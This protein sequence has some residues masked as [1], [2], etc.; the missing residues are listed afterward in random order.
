MVERQWIKGAGLV[1]LV[2]A[3]NGNPNQDNDETT[4]QECT[5]VADAGPDQEG[6]LGVGV[7]MD[8]AGSQDC[9]TSGDAIYTWS[10]DSIP[11]DSE[12]DATAFSDN[13]S[14][15]A[16]ATSFVPDAIG[17]YLVAL[18]VE[19]SGVLSELD[20]AIVE[21]GASG[22]VP[23]ADCGGDLEVVLG[24][25]AEL[26]GSGSSDPDG[27]S[28]SYRWTLG[29]VP[30]GSSLDSSAIFDAEAVQASFVPDLVGTY[31]VYL[32]V[33][34][35]Q[36]ESEPAYCTVTAVVPNQA[37]V[38]DAGEGGVMAPCDDH[39]LQL[40]GYGSYDP[41]GLPLEYQW[42]VLTT[43]EGSGASAEPCDT[44]IVGCY[45]AFDD[46]FAADPIFTWDLEGTYTLQ[47]EVY[48]GDLWSAPDVVAY[49][50]SECP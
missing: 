3:C 15:A 33:S 40:D 5:P 28:I 7:A 26:D 48:D 32:T 45:A 2:A 24:E 17:T 19:H 14:A 43:P 10:F 36:Q 9:A 41:E 42:G 1:V 50:V 39:L 16:Q 20:V 46:T 12:L 30:D 13:A 37:P 34:D 38:A 27:E 35:G 49:T 4:P 47:L 11:A 29:A 25:R 31:S 21:V 18:Q 22:G 44:G 6:T 8:G 23:L